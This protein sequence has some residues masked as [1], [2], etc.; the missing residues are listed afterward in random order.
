MG[1]R[2]ALVRKMELKEVRQNVEQAAQIAAD[3]LDQESAPEPIKAWL[4]KGRIRKLCDLEPR[5]PYL[6]PKRRKK[7][8]CIIQLC[9]VNR[10]FMNTYRVGLKA[11]TMHV[12]YSA[13]PIIALIETLI[14][15]VCVTENWAQEGTG[16]KKCVN[17]LNS[18]GIFNHKD[19]ERIHKLR[20]LRNDIHLY[21]N[22]RDIKIHEGK[23][24]LYNVAVLR[25]KRV[26][27]LLLKHYKM[28]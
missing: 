1:E 19:K 27:K 14:H 23:P 20:E 25:L 22:D 12:W 21:L 5:W 17:I 11:G 9:D 10:F 16:F 2:F 13:I 7:C 8:A 15:E 3:Y 6:P 4:P 18:K 28:D 24:R 26:E